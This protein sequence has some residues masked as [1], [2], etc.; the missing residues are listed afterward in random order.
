[1]RSLRARPSYGRRPDS[2][3][4]AAP[5][6]SQW[7]YTWVVPVDGK[8]PSLAGKPKSLYDSEPES[9]VPWQKLL[10]E[11]GLGLLD[12]SI[13]QDSGSEWHKI[14]RPL[15]LAEALTARERGIRVR[16]TRSPSCLP[17]AL[18]CHQRGLH[19]IVRAAGSVTSVTCKPESDDGVHLGET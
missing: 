1:M 2:I 9:A 17:T 4:S 16:T 15:R 11:L 12:A 6:P 8:Q 14:T 3:S 5:V 7:V 19:H 18:C 13:K 10:D